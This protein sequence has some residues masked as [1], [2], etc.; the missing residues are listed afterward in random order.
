MAPN[1]VKGGTGVGVVGVWFLDLLRVSL[2]P[3]F[4]V[5]GYLVFKG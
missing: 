1:M 2:E 4:R 5:Q 3:Y